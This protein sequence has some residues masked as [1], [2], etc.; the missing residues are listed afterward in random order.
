MAKQMQKNISCREVITC[1]ECR[2]M[3]EAR[4][5]EKG[6]LICPASGIKITDNDFLQ[7]CG[8]GNPFDVW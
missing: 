5:N 8:K 3:Q 4:I 7:L 6:F 2:Y 1:K